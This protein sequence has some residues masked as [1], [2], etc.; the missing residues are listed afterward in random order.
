KAPRPAVEALDRP[1]ETPVVAARP[2]REVAIR[3]LDTRAPP[4]EPSEGDVFIDRGAVLPDRY[5][6]TRVRVMVRDPGTLFVYWEIPPEAGG[7]AWEIASLDADDQTLQAFRVGHEGASGYLNVASA[8]VERVTL[9]PVQQ[10]L[11]TEPW[12]TVD[13]G[14]SLPEPPLADGPAPW[15]EVPVAFPDRD[16]PAWKARSV[17]SDVPAAPKASQRRVAEPQSGD[18]DAPGHGHRSKPLEAPDATSSTLPAVRR[19]T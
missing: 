15:V 19:R 5:P 2:P 12:A 4:R 7:E 3:T 17:P 13:L 11:A 9:R 16:P 1:V 8:S 18:I 6:G 10:G 14:S